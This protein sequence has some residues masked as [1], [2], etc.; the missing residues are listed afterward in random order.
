MSRTIVVTGGGTGIGRAVAARFAAASDAVVIIGRRAEVLEKAAAET[1][2]TPLVCDVTDAA[3]VEAL[4][5]RLPGQ[6]DVL[7]NCAGG[8]TDITQPPADGLAGLVAGWQANFNANV[9]SAVLTTTA[10]TDRLRAGGTVVQIGSIA[11]DR[12]AAGSYG[13]AKAALS[14]WNGQLAAELGPRGITANVVSCGYIEDTEFFRDRMTE[15]R[16]QFLI[17]ETAVKR[18]GTPADVAGVIEFLASPAARDLTG[19]VI[20]L[21]GGAWTTR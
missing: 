13:A 7:V 20:N 8:N 17:E 3:A 16:R 12:G 15:Q 4:L 21:N 10:L 14:R 18:P 2:A 9:V 11:A 1:G 19:Q 6:V 5:R